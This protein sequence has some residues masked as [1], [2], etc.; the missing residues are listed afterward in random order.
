MSREIL[1]KIY[2]DGEGA[3]F[4]A[5]PNEGSGLY[6]SHAKTLVD[7]TG[8]VRHHEPRTTLYGLGLIAISPEAKAHL[9]SRFADTSS[10]DTSSSEG[11]FEIL[12]PEEVEGGWKNGLFAFRP[13]EGALRRVL[14]AEE[15]FL[16]KDAF[17]YSP[18][19]WDLMTEMKNEALRTLVL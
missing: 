4:E 18:K 11:D 5:A 17:L 13:T 12:L 3:V 1:L 7:K 9:L 10:Y 16:L 8:R 6:L 2:M 14:H 19:A 15:R